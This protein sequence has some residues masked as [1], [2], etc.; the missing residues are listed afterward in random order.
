MVRGLPAMSSS[1]PGGALIPVFGQ[2]WA[3]QTRYLLRDDMTRV[4]REFDCDVVIADRAISR[5]HAELVWEGDRLMLVPVSETNGTLVNGRVIDRPTELRPDDTAEFTDARFAV[6]VFINATPASASTQH[7]PE[8]DRRITA[9]VSAD[10][11]SYSEMMEKDDISTMQQITRG[12]AIFDGLTQQHGGRTI[13]AVGDSILLEF[14]SVSKAFA[15][16]T[17]FQERIMQSAEGDNRI[18]HLLF[19]IGVNVGEIVT[20]RDGTVYGTAVNIA[21]RI[22]SKAGPGR[23]LA[24]QMARDL[25]VRLPDGYGFTDAGVHELK[26]I[27]GTH[28]LYALERPPGVA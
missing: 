15:A 12:R 21:A 28:R 16:T 1:P 19:R 24:S 20:R 4:G 2:H 10:V 6:K 23:I 7:S 25:A 8:I 18:H 17:E 14:A 22:Q 26:N 5:R 11:M 3:T 9:I 27:S 13:D